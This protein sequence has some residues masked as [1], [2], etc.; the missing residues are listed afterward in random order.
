VSTWTPWETVHRKVAI[1]GRASDADGR[2]VPGV[3][4]AITSGPKA[5]HLPGESSALAAHGGGVL[6]KRLPHTLS[7]LDGIFFFLDLPPGKYA[8]HASHCRAGRQVEKVVS[9]T[10][11][12]EP[13][14]RV[15]IPDVV[16]Q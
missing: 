5:L 11:R 8:L 10:V 15:S 4:V 13:K 2:P 7:R 16:L 14:G 1:C 6:T 12:A 9:A 3:L